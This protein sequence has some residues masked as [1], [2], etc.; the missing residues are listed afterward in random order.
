MP[1]IHTLA[2]RFNNGYNASLWT[3]SAPAFK[4]PVGANYALSFTQNALMES[5]GGYIYDLTSSSISLELV[6]IPASSS[7]TFDF[8]INRSGGTPI[9][10][11]IDYTT[12]QIIVNSSVEETVDYLR[13]IHRF[14]RMRES[15]GT[16]YVEA[17]TDGYDWNYELHSFATSS[18][19]ITNV[20]VQLAVSNSV[21][22]LTY[23]ANINTLPEFDGSYEI[24]HVYKKYNSS[25]GYEENV[26]VGSKLKIVQEINT[27]GSAMTIVLPL[28]LTDDSF[29]ADADE[30]VD[31]SGIEIITE[32]GDT[33]ISSI[34][35]SITNVPNLGDKIEIYEFSSYY[36]QGKKIF[37]GIV[38]FWRFINNNKSISI[39]LSSYGIQ[40]DNK[41]VSVYQET[42]VTE[43]TDTGSLDS[44]DSLYGFGGGS[45][46]VYKAGQTFQVATPTDMTSISMYGFFYSSPASPYSMNISLKVYT[47]TPTSL[48]TLIA[49][50]TKYLSK[51]YNS[52]NYEYINFLFDS[53]ISLAASTTYC[54][55]IEVLSPTSTRYDQRLKLGY[56]TT[57][58]YAS[59][60]RYLYSGG[61]WSTSGDYFFKVNGFTTSVA[62][63]EFLSQDPSDIVR[64]L[65]D[66][67][68]SQGINIQYTDDSIETTNTTV[69]YTF[70]YNTYYEA[71]RKCVEL[72]PANWYWY[73]DPSTNIIYFKGKS[74]SVDRKINMSKNIDYELDY[75][76]ENMTN[77]AYL[78]GGDTGSGIN[79][80]VKESNQNSIDR[81][82][83]WLSST[84]DNRITDV[85][86]GELLVQ[87]KVNQGSE[88]RFSIKNLTIPITA[89]N[90][91]IFRIGQSLGFTNSNDLVNFLQLQI[92]SKEYDSD[93]VIFN[94]EVLPPTLNKR[95]EDIR[96]NLLQEETRDN[97]SLS[98]T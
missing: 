69:S 58:G 73:I 13:E 6:D 88:P 92:M 48:G 87:S 2:D 16:V 79:L 53:T 80:L 85:I 27:S 10:I 24:K 19:T 64:T 4:M 71:L 59:G 38:T 61:S 62:S 29:N 95:I 1:K 33:L 25:G 3:F 32:G 43:Y 21:P 94:L 41:L 98:D 63:N 97:P 11:S 82:G 67:M 66:T 83:A 36:K 54:A 84:T 9:L 12:I 77:V 42:A 5:S 90:P 75:S 7:C 50:T 20:F 18:V 52:D 30:I 23:I 74:F 14:I 51:D 68:Q 45:A 8:S 40:L 78:S 57:G 17:S 22:F 47:G 96:R 81:Y 86:S 39:S 34:E 89:Y 55:I 46:P 37:E 28:R 70:T 76:L 49:S 35:Y 15:N 91:H 26:I 93:S 65:V 31:E 60:A 56:Y 72:A 44:F